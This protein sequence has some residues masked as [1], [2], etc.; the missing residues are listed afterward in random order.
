[1]NQ[2]LLSNLIKTIRVYKDQVSLE[3]FGSEPLSEGSLTP[4]NHLQKNRDESVR[5]LSILMNGR[6][7]RI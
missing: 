3:Y 7:D 6:E 1:M 5:S 4:E 2:E